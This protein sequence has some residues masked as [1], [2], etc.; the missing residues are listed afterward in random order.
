VGAVTSPR[1]NETSTQYRQRAGRFRLVQDFTAEHLRISTAPKNPR[2]P[3]RMAKT[4]EQAEFCPWCDAP[5]DGYDCRRCAYT[6]SLRFRVPMRAVYL[7]LV[8][9]FALG[10]A[11]GI[12][13]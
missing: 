9:D 12:H 10:V 6:P 11:V 1:Y 4:R 5:F 13:F 3:L 7:F 8:I 2:K